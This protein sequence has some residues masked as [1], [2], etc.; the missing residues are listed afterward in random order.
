MQRRLALRAR[1]IDLEKIALH[2]SALMDIKTEDIWTRGKHQRIVDARSVLC[3]WAVHEL[4]V[5][6]TSMGRKLGLSTPAISKSVTRGKQISESKGFRLI[7][8]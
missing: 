1:G 2:V 3:F 8:S 7:E 4:G 6:M 5:S